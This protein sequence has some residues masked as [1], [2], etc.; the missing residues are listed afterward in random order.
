VAFEHEQ[1][2]FVLLLGAGEAF[3]KIKIPLKPE[4]EM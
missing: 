4:R 1:H 2:G 3:L